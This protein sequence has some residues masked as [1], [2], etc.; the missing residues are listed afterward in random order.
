[1]RL[2]WRVLWLNTLVGVAATVLLIIGPWTVSA[3]IRPVEAL[4]L[5]AGLASM[6]VA[7]AILLRWGLAPLNRLTRLMARVDLLRPGQRLPP[8]GSRE[9]ATLIGAFNAML[10]R[11]E[12]ER[13]TSTARALSAQEDER[14]RIARELHDEIGQRLTALLL[15]IGR[16]ADRTPRPLQEELRHA[17]ETTRQSLD[18]VRGIARRLRPDVLENLGLA[19]AL[20]ALAT[21]FDTQTPRYV[22]CHVQPGLPPLSAGLELVLYRVAQEALTNAARH[23]NATAVDLALIPAGVPGRAG[24][25]LRID[26]NGEG[27]NNAAESAGIHG[28]RERALLAGGTLDI[29]PGP[30][31]GTRLTLFVPTD[32]CSAGGAEPP[33]GEH[34]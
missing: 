6:L 13:G 24:V 30:R 31:G 21:Q 12:T 16:L 22:R 33:T 15:D 2:F 27:M 25:L 10:Q 29:R 32:C 3:P 4:V 18:E 11:L 7:N 19:S 14:R 20:T 34:R 9:I 17:Q 28:M 23:S 26:D 8:S 5:I 1:M